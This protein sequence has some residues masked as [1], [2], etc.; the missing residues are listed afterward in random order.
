MIDD[1][2]IFARFGNSVSHTVKQYSEIAGMLERR[3]RIFAPAGM[4]WSVVILSSTFKEQVASM[5][6]AIAVVF[7]NSLMFGPLRTSI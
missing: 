6:S 4:M 5:L 7:G 1:P 2:S 3:G